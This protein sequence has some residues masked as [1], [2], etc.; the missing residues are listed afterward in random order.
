MGHDTTALR[1]ASGQ[2]RLAQLLYW[3]GALDERGF[4]AAIEKHIPNVCGA[5]GVSRDELA[6]SLGPV[7]AN[8]V[9]FVSRPVEFLLR[10]SERPELATAPNA[11]STDGLQLIPTITFRDGDLQA[12][13][14]VS[15]LDEQLSALAQERAIGRAR[16]VS[17]LQALYDR[18]QSLSSHQPGH[19]DPVVEAAIARME[20]SASEAHENRLN[21]MDLRYAAVKRAC[22][23]NGRLHGES[24]AQAP[25]AEIPWIWKACNDFYRDVIGGPDMGHAHAFDG[26]QFR[27]FCSSLKMGFA[28]VEEILEEF[29]TRGPVHGE[30]PRTP[31]PSIRF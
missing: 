25:A 4:N 13:L 29:R 16:R 11:R 26:P 31:S 3:T 19:V 23:I 2:L 14:R 18:R 8:P 6:R 9:W 12:I 10:L 7:P 15:A 1:D 21:L 17:E 27:A 28:E 20:A 24:A 22:K 30:T 5:L